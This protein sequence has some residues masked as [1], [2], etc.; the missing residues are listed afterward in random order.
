MEHGTLEDTGSNQSY[1]HMHLS[2]ASSN[3][4]LSPEATAATLGSCSSSMVI[5][6]SGSSQQN[7]LM[8]ST[9]HPHLGPQ[10]LAMLIA[11]ILKLHTLKR[12]RRQLLL[13]TAAAAAARWRYHQAC[14]Y[15]QLLQQHFKCRT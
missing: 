1:S 14:C 6:K 12:Q 9:L 4:A 3:A 7:T 11:T 10:Q 15:I 13:T 2:S 8:H 5:P